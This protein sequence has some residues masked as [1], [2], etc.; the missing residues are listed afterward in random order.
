MLDPAITTKWI[1]VDL[2]AIAHNLQ[3]VRTRLYERTRILSVVKADAYGHGM[4]RTAEALEQA[5]S[6]MLGVTFVEEGLLLRAGGIR[7]P[8]LVFGPFL[9]EEVESSIEANLTLTV[10]T[11]EQLIW[12]KQQLSEKKAKLKVHIKIETGMGR[13]GFAAEEALQAAGEIL[14]TEGLMLEGVYSHF[15]TAMWKNKK[16]VCEQYQNFKSVLERLQQGGVEIPLKH[17][18]N[19][20]AILGMPETQ[21]DMVRTGTLLYGQYPAGHFAHELELKNTWIMK[22]RMLSIKSLPPG[23]P[24]GYERT[25][26]TKKK[27]MLG[28]IPVGFTDGFGVEPR[29]KPSNGL[30]LIKSLLKLIMSYYNLPASALMV[31]CRGRSFPV[32]GKPGMQLSMIDIGEAMDLNCKSVLEIPIRRTAANP[33]IRKL[34]IKNGQLL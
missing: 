19:S 14:A 5:G 3:Q 11:G 27:T 29:A 1:E 20:A 2:D 16:Y 28:I 26:V 7:L 24:V 9:E 34:Y 18:A 6:D 32:L 25:F 13:S 22:A 4:L 33:S 10:S 12:L 21:L 17:I 31:Y 23:H 8:I 15:A 30:G